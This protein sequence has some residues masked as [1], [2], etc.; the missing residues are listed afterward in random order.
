MVWNIK[1]DILFGKRNE[2]KVISWFNKNMYGDDWFK[3]YK[4]ERKQVDFKNTQIIGELKTRTCSSTYYPDTMFGY[5]KM[6]YLREKRQIKENE[7]RQFV[8]YFLFTNGLYKWVYEE[9]KENQYR[10]DEFIHQEK[11]PMPY[12][13]VLKEYLEL[14]TT[15]INSTTPP[16][17]DEADYLVK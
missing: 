5:N 8:F 7:T 14:V 12:C 4:L 17:H 10:I 9:G 13:Y 2:K 15:D 16:A 6:K 3:A 11:G 1:E